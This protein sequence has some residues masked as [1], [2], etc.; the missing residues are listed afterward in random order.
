MSHSDASFLLSTAAATTG[1]LVSNA[2]D[3]IADSLNLKGVTTAVPT[4]IGPGGTAT[5]PG[6]TA[7]A[8]PAGV[9]VH[10]GSTASSTGMAVHPV[11][12]AVPAGGLKTQVPA[13][14][15]AATATSTTAR[16]S[17]G[18]YHTGVD[19]HHAR[20]THHKHPHLDKLLHGSSHHHGS[21]ATGSALH[22][23]TAR[24]ASSYSTGATAGSHST[25]QMKAGVGYH[26]PHLVGGAMGQAG[27]A[28][29]P[30]AAVAAAPAGWTGEGGVTD[31]ELEVS[32]KVKD[33][34]ATSGMQQ[35][36]RVTVRPL[37]GQGG[38][39]DAV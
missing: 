25:H 20:H 19:T 7:T 31:G 30:A 27:G 26:P 12:S 4:S 18:Y 39:N 17:D 35:P 16:P 8:A 2:A 24:P 28:A 36:V 14:T 3:A 13:A 23:S 5:Y 32:Q 10:T 6:S 22:G 33:M 21:T 34:I 1:E 38:L 15:A 9:A 37:T 29:V 11:P